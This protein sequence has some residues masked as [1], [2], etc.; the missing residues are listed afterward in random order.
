M[1][2]MQPMNKVQNMTRE[3]YIRHHT[4][5]TIERGIAIGIIEPKEQP[6]NQPT[7]QNEAAEPTL[8]GKTKI[9]REIEKCVHRRHQSTGKWPVMAEVANRLHLTADNIIGIILES[10]VLDYTVPAKPAKSN[11]DAVMTWSIE[12]KEAA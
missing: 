3:D 12:L 6:I 4:Q 1:N 10:E 8:R 9:E 5:Q 7:Q 11:V 2:K